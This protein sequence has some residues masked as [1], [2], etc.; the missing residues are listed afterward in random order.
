LIEVNNI[1]HMDCLEGMDSMIEQGI[2]VD[3]IITDPPYGT[4]QCK[5]DSIIPFDEMWKRLNKL[6][7]DRTPII[8]FGKQ[9]FTSYLNISNIKDF[10]YEVIWEKD[11][12]TDFGNANRKPLNIHENISV[13]YSKQPSYTRI[14]DEGEPYIRKNKRSNG[15]NDLNF[16]SDN[17]GIWVNKGGRTP[18][19][20]RRFNRVSAGGQ[21]PIHPTEKPVEL[22]EWLVKSYTDEGDLVLDFAIGSGTTAIACINTNR[23]FIG[24]ELQEEYYNIAIN[25]INNHINNNNLQDRYSQLA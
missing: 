5:W 16:K 13:F 19:T 3:A 18:V 7:Y 4:T 24:F 6:S 21:K 2:K 22:M 1:Y 8:L 10:R 12:G 9:P 20:I 23:N 15:E 14:M 25:R 11:K 17:S